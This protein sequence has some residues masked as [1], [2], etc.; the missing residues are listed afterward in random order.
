VLT[1]YG[2]IS[3]RFVVRVGNIATISRMGLFT[4]VSAYL[5]HVWPFAADRWQHT[6]ILLTRICFECEQHENM[7]ILQHFIVQDKNHIIFVTI[8]CREWLYGYS[9]CK[10]TTCGYKQ[11]SNIM[12]II[13]S[14]KNRV[15]NK[16]WLN[17]NI[18]AFYHYTWKLGDPTPRFASVCIWVMF[19]YWD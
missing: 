16:V 14:T 18:K 1:I 9:R 5:C 11:G 3:R 10:F 13:I 6:N 19:K 12:N 17:K 7:T 8:C 2:K 15:C 4:A